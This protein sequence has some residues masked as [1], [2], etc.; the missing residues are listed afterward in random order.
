MKSK[1]MFTNQNHQVHNVY[2][3]QVGILVLWWFGLDFDML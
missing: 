3:I 2:E 1:R